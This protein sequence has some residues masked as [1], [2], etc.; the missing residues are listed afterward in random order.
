MKI[1]EATEYLE[2]N[3]VIPAGFYSDICFQ[4]FTEWSNL[5]ASTT[6]ENS[7]EST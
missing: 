1:A 3:K 7:R 6:R 2:F 5:S 4:G